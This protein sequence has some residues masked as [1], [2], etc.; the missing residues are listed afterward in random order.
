MAVPEEPAAKG[1]FDVGLEIER[2]F[3][4]TDAW[5]PEGTGIRVRQGYIANGETLLVRVR[6]QD[7]RAFLTLKG[8]TTG[9]SRAEYEYP[10]PAE[11]AEE[12]LSLAEAPPIEKTRYRIPFGAHVWEVDVF[13]GEN[14][15][16]VLAE[17]E[18]K[19]EDEPFERPPWLGAE[20]SGDP[21]YYN[22][23]LALRPFRSWT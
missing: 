19:R 23:N 3:L 8:R 11:D 21:R 7:E 10:I 2:K 22:S 6:R 17:I 9:V 4:V 13:S 18:L 20:V 15:G 12:L 5:R 16:L 14:E 1:G